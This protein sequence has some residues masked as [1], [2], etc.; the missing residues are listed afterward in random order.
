[1]KPNPSDLPKDRREFAAPDDLLRIVAHEF[2][3]VLNNIALQV[4]VME[5]KGMPP[6]LQSDLAVIGQTVRG[7]AWMIQQLR[8]FS[9]SV[10]RPLEAVDLHAAVHRVVARKSRF[11]MVALELAPALPRVLATEGDLERLVELLLGSAA[12]ALTRDTGRITLQTEALPDRVRLRLTDTGPQVSAEDLRRFFQPFT[13][14]RQGGDGIAPALCKAIVRR[15][16]GTI[17]ADNLPVGGMAF[18]VELRLASGEE[19]PLPRD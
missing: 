9:Q 19:R 2:N 16:Q 10:E 15:L 7:A 8:Q 1:M 3:N 6:E 11:S 5:Q 12:A 13:L 4:A 17:H 18:A 14:L